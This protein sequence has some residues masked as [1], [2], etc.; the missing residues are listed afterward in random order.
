MDH[1]FVVSDWFALDIAKLLYCDAQVALPRKQR[2]Y[3]KA[4]KEFKRKQRQ[5]RNWSGGSD[6]VWA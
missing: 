4:C 1:K 3:H 5:A 2:I 6:P